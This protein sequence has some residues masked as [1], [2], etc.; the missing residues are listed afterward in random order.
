ME[1]KSGIM[2]KREEGGNERRESLPWVVRMSC[3][4]GLLSCIMKLLSCIMGLLSV[5]KFKGQFTDLDTVAFAPG[6]TMYCK[7]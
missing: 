7:F 3:I 4:I 2:G 5:P 1:E 6:V